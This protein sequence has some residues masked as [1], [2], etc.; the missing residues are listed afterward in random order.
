M[1]MTK[2]LSIIR[3]SKDIE[4]MLITTYR[5]PRHLYRMNH[6][7][8]RNTPLFTKL[9]YEMILEGEAIPSYEKF[10]KNYVNIYCPREDAQSVGLQANL[11]YKAILTDIHFYFLLLESKRFDDVEMSFY[12]DILAKSDVLLTK[13]GTEIGL[14]LFSGDKVYE[15]SK[16]ISIQRM[17]GMLAY[18]V[19]AF[20]LEKR[21]NFEDADGKG[22]SLYDLQDVEKVNRLFDEHEVMEE[23]DLRPEDGVD[24]FAVLTGAT[25]PS[26]RK[27]EDSEPKH[28]V[29]FGGHVEPGVLEDM[30]SRGLKVHHIDVEIEGM[31]PF[32]IDDGKMEEVRRHESY[33]REYGNRSE[34]FNFDQ[35]IVEHADPKEHIAINAGAGSGKTTTLIARIMYLLDMD[36]VQSLERIAMI[37]FTNEAANNMEKALARELVGR[38]RTTG[39]QKYIKHLN[40][41]RRMDIMTIPAFAKTILSQFGQHIGIGTGFRVSAMTLVRRKIIDEQIDNVL[42]EYGI[43]N[44]FEGMWYHEARSFLEMLWDKFEQKGIVAEDLRK[45]VGDM[46]DPELADAFVEIIARADE[47]LHEEKVKNDTLGISDLTRYLKK[48]EGSGAPL[49]EL[50]DRY[51]Y[52][53]VDEFQ[54]TDITQIQFITSIIRATDICLTVVGD[55]KQG[56]YRFRGADS[57]AFTVLNAA[58]RN[59]GL[60]GCTTYRLSENFR[61]SRPLVEGM[62]RHF[63]IWRSD[64]LE[65]LPNDEPMLSRRESI[66]EGGLVLEEGTI[67]ADEIRERYEELGRTSDGGVD[68]E[69]QPKRTLAILVRKN[70]EART[71]G[72]MLRNDGSIHNF[73]VRMDGTLFD[74]LAARDLHILINS[75]IFPELR[76]SLYALAA[77]AFAESDDIQNFD[78]ETKNVHR[79]GWNRFETYITARPTNFRVSEKWESSLSLLRENPLL[80]VIDAFLDASGYQENL[81][82]DGMTDIDVL[83]YEMNIQKIMMLIH[84]NFSDGPLDILA[85]HDWLSIQISTNKEED[86]AEIDDNR[87]DGDIVRVLTVHRSKGLEFETVMIPFTT[88]RFL[89]NVEYI[90]RDAIVYVDAAGHPEYGWKFIDEKSGFELVTEHYGRLKNDED[91]EQVREETRLLYVAMTRAVD[92]LHIYEINDRIRCVGRPET[93]GDLLTREG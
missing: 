21:R 77:T 18:V 87:F 31:T 60:I 81:R 17:Q 37:T 42:K 13:D 45:K 72:E 22:M 79:R 83:Q 5:R 38:L 29:I 40:D 68:R 73:E 61:S 89:R 65:L 14:Q 82:Q 69:T 78:R 28:S 59:K 66:C 25:V 86:E 3:S 6:S 41:L 62:E 52:L 4:N 23:L 84:E 74:S 85:L 91:D 71:V 58:M 44:P 46:E 47:A 10:V 20:P 7:T 53:F 64:P 49:D 57:S 80:P 54:D 88:G 51:Q 93:W 75:W 76:E 32:R 34:R 30:K 36:K 15:N 70:D 43:D 35:Y 11:A 27:P 55:V 24:R 63:S 67:N 19:H 39:D 8:N 56:I 92:R 48:I 90:K 12:H 50:A 26:I 2:V 16:R 1:D 33:L 9:L